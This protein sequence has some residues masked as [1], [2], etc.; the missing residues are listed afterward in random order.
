MTSH[1]LRAAALS[2]AVEEEKPQPISISTG[3]CVGWCHG[4]AAM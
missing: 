1:P 2:T 3:S 4:L